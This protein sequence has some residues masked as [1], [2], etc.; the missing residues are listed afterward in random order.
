MWWIVRVSNQAMCLYSQPIQVHHPIRRGS[1]P[2][3]HSVFNYEWKD[4]CSQR[5]YLF[6][7]HIHMYMHFS[8]YSNRAPDP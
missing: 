1:S 3:Y 8:P 6:H 7:L 4:S 5:P 2:T